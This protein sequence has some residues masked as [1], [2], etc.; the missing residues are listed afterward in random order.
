MI[1]KFYVKICYC[2]DS[3]L[4]K[5]HFDCCERLIEFFEFKFCKNYSDS[6]YAKGLLKNLIH[7]LCVA[8]DLCN[9]YN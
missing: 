2:I 1:N 9:I 3:S 7:R 8:K 5:E 6:K 4:T